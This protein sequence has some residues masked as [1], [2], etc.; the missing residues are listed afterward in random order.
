MYALW[1][2]C[3][4]QWG[5]LSTPSKLIVGGS[6]AIAVTNIALLATEPSEAATQVATVAATSGAM[7]LSGV[8][9]ATAT[10]F[11]GLAALAATAQA[12]GQSGLTSRK[13][14]CVDGGELRIVENPTQDPALDGAT[15]YS[16]DPAQN[17]PTTPINLCDAL[18]QG[19]D[20][21]GAVLRGDAGN[22]GILST[23]GNEA[24]ALADGTAFACTIDGQLSFLAAKNLRSDQ[25]AADM[26]V[27]AQA[28]QNSIC[29]HLASL[30]SQHGRGVMVYTQP[31]N[32]TAV[33]A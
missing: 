12:Q 31:D 8:S 7:I 28:G 4:E 11:G 9:A 18:S 30:Q 32:A 3:Q 15:V 20:T 1:K 14:Q 29:P 22:F 33:V 26:Q 5:K 10:I 24:S 16:Q 2:A 19:A 13:H 23:T 21:I 17:V 25:P 6:A 27:L